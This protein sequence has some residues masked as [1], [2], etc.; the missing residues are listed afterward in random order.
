MGRKATLVA[1]ATAA[2]AAG[3]NAW[4]V[5]ASSR[6][7][8][9]LVNGRTD[10]WTPVPDDNSN[11]PGT[12]IAEWDVGR[13]VTRRSLGPFG[14]W[15]L[16]RRG[17]TSLFA[18]HFD[19]KRRHPERTW[20]RARRLTPTIS[21][22][23]PFL[24]PFSACCSQHWVHDDL[25]TYAAAIEDDSNVIAIFSS[26]EGMRHPDRTVEPTRPALRALTL[27]CS[28]TS[29]LQCTCSLHR[30]LPSTRSACASA[31]ASRS[32]RASA[33]SRTASTTTRVLVRAFSSRSPPSRSP[34]LP[35]SLPPTL[36]AWRRP[37]CSQPSR[38]VCERSLAADTS[39]LGGPV[40]R[41]YFD[42]MFTQ[43]TDVRLCS[44]ALAFVP[45]L[46]FT[47]GA[48]PPLFRMRWDA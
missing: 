23:E 32:P 11:S 36:P 1:A 29:A 10:Y 45:A 13:Y 31:S 5:G 12:C 26:T 40:N 34:S 25:R 48:E 44:A 30:T 19:R 3:A 46:R 37:C 18:Q 41:D 22:P 2:L 8:L 38:G 35:P 33:S 43:M 20:L 15:C 6:T 28:L 9:P 39:G 27:P 7:I 47:W 14:L 42:Y 4:R 24:W 17:A 21:E 16:T